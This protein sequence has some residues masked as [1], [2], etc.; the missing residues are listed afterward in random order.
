LADELLA[1]RTRL[2]P[3]G[4][5]TMPTVS[6]ERGS[7]WPSQEDFLLLQA[8]LLQ[9]DACASAWQDWK[10]SGNLR[11]LPVQ[12]WQ[13]LPLLYRNLTNQGIKDESLPELRIHYLT[14]LA[15]NKGLI[16]GPNPPIVEEFWGIWMSQ[17]ENRCRGDSVGGNTRADTVGVSGR[18]SL[19]VMRCEGGRYSGLILEKG[20]G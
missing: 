17:Q 3:D 11:K 12:S 14:S 9:G 20:V 1:P 10:G 16:R 13:L 19:P 15:R 4:Y 7:V 8:S 2:N 5:A 6:T 18:R